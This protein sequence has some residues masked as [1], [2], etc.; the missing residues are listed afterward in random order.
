MPIAFLMLECLDKYG[1]VN[2]KHEAA[3]RLYQIIAS[4][5]GVHELFDSQTGKGMG[6]AQQGWTCAI[7]IELIAMLFSEDR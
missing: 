6:A 4:D 2:E 3:L 5:D 7:F 1:F